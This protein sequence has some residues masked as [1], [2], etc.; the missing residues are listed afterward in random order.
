MSDL[1]KDKSHRREK[2]T[3]KAPS[4]ASHGVRSKE[5]T[6]RTKE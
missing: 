4:E 3:S 2:R 1:L 5:T 6:G